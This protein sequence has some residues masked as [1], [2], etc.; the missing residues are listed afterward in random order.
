MSTL[1]DINHD[2]QALDDLLTEAGGD[3]SDPAVEATITKWMSELDTDINNKVDGYAALVSE[4][5][6]RA[7][8]RQEESDRLRKRSQ[9]DKNNAKFLK[10]RLLMVF[11]MRGIKKIETNRYRVTVA[12][13]G[14]VLPMTIMDD[15]VPATY[16]KQPPPVVD[17]ETIRSE[18]EAGVVLRFAK[19][20]KR[21]THLNI[22]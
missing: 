6:L 9:L 18:L 12:K 1:L 4:L 3:I 21:G 19:L 16:M 5:T 2:M 10:D 17:T 15:A 22:K 13:N 8:A 20:G 11:E 7:K 14:G